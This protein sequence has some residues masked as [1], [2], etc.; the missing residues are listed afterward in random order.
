M[1]HTV[2]PPT[3]TLTSSSQ[4]EGFH[5]GLL[6]TFTG[7]AEFDIAVDTPLNVSSAW[8]KSDPF[9]DLKNTIITSIEEVMGKPMGYETNLTIYLQNTMEGNENYILTIITSSSAFTA[10]ITD[11]YTRTITEINMSLI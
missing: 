6:L 5:I 1:L 2:P 8:S 4:E 9:S 7:R 3:I 10:G 11:T